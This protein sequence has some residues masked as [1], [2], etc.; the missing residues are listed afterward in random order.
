MDNLELFPRLLLPPPPYYE[1][2]AVTW[3][4]P[5]K[6]LHL[7]PHGGDCLVPR[8]ACVSIGDSVQ[9]AGTQ[10]WVVCRNGRAQILP[11]YQAEAHVF[12]GDL[13]I[14]VVLKEITE[15]A[16]QTAAVALAHVHYRPHIL[17]GRT[18]RLIVRTDHPLLPAVVGYLELATP[19]Y[20]NKARAA[21]LNAPFQSGTITWTAWDKPTIQRY[22]HVLVRIARCVVAPELRGVGLG[23]LLVRH[24]ATF[25]RQRWQV[26]GWLPLFLEISAD[27]LKYVPFAAHAGMT[28]IGDTEGNLARVAADVDYLL[29]NAA[30]VQA[31]EI[32]S[33]E[34]CGIVDQQVARLNRALALLDR[35]GW[36]HEDLVGRL[37]TLSPTTRLRDVAVLQELLSF[38]KPTYLQG[39]TPDAAAFLAARVADKRPPLVSASPLPPIDRLKGPILLRHVTLTWRSQVCQTPRAHHVQQ[40]F[41]LS[42]AS[43][44]DTTVIARLS[45]TI[46]AGSISVI[47]GPSGSGKTTL[48][49]LLAA[50]G[51]LPPAALTVSGTIA[52]P[53]NYRPG[54]FAPLCSQQALIDLFGGHDIR[55][56][57]HLMGHVGLSDAFVALQRFQDLSKGQQ[58]R[59]LLA[60]LI[61]TR[62]NVWLLDE[63]CANLDPLTARVVA[64]TV[65]RTARHLGVTV[66][67][68]APHCDYF[69][70]TLRPDTVL[71]LTSTWEY[72]ILE[73]APAYTESVKP[74]QGESAPCIRAVQ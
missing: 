22:I 25:A 55:T 72:R 42:T 62:A 53:P 64:E 41:G 36:S 43:T 10:A 14:K 4:G 73:G 7:R 26:A 59:A 65:Q 63:F 54:V 18:A 71:Q 38:P 1:V 58:Y 74:Q 19:F 27:M 60:H 50:G 47:L 69:A 16:E 66:V 21:I 32:V 61:T 20:M 11:P 2:A 46:R 17:F 6:A 24:A 34:V 13:A 37:H 35:Q 8:S 33:E 31:G 44:I 49:N 48:L 5:L 57:L 28:Y 56:T 45:C 70:S 67:V 23:Q 40:A 15:E 52:W 3:H 29:R 51:T 68:A 12:L 30:R 39:L 9:W